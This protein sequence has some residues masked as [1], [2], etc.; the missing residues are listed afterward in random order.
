MSPPLFYFWYFRL[1]GMD[2]PGKFRKTTNF[3]KTKGLYQSYYYNGYDI[4]KGTLQYS[5]NQHLNKDLTL[6]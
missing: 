3:L 2:K 6:A 4:I 1:T 5:T